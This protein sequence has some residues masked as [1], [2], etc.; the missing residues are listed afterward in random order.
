[1]QAF[2]TSLF[3]F[4]KSKQVD[5]AL[6][7]RFDEEKDDALI[8][9]LKN[10]WLAIKEINLDAAKHRNNFCLWSPIG[11]SSHHYA[12]NEILP[13]FLEIK[14]SV[15]VEDFKGMLK[16]GDNTDEFAKFNTGN[17]EFWYTNKSNPPEELKDY[18]SERGEATM[19]T[20]VSGYQR[21][22]ER[23]F[24]NWKRQLAGKDKIS[25]A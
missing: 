5:A 24:I 10:F 9:I 4:L 7:Q 19:Y 15:Q 8:A 3:Y 18:P 17:G 2:S 14:K 1:M 13:E 22:G 20:G 6:V 12:L 16:A 21:L 25:L 23:L 11:V